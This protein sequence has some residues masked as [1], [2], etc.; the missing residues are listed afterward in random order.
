M[1]NDM[2]RGMTRSEKNFDGTA[3]EGEAVAASKSAIEARNGARLRRGPKDHGS[4]VVLQAKDAIGVIGMMV[5]HENMAQRPAPRSE[6]RL[7]RGGI[8]GIYRG[9]LAGC[10]IVK[11]QAIIVGENRKLKDFE[12]RH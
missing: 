12:Q 8:G 2:A 6:C 3:S 9:G 1:V 11:Q 7:D 10:G 4:I 5:G